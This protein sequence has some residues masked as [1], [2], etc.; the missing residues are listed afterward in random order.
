MSEQFF[1]IPT[2]QYDKAAKA[3]VEKEEREFAKRVAEHQ[4]KQRTCP[5]EPEQLLPCQT[6]FTV[7]MDF[8]PE[9]EPTQPAPKVSK[10][11]MPTPKHQQAVAEPQKK[12]TKLDTATP[13]DENQKPEEPPLLEFEESSDEE[14]EPVKKV[15]TIEIDDCHMWP[16]VHINICNH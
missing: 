3:K 2:E 15:Q 16:L 4:K 9:P 1:G 7:P 6:L 5:V 11:K 10:R 14:E 13:V 8:P 12:V